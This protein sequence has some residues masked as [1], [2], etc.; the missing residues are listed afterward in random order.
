[1]PRRARPAGAGLLEWTIAFPVFLLLGLATLQVILIAFHGMYLDYSAREVARKVSVHGL[2]WSDQERFASEGLS[3][4]WPGQLVHPS[5]NYVK[6]RTL[7]MIAVNRLSPTDQGI[8]D[9]TDP[10]DGRFLPLSPGEGPIP[11][12]RSGL[13][14]LAEASTVVIELVS[15]YELSIPF[16]GRLL[17]ETIAWSRGCQSPLG[18]TEDC[19]FLTGKHPLHPG[20]TMLPITRQGR[21]LLQPAIQVAGG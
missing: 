4:M 19:L 17:S 21:A 6:A 16:A 1:M 2:D 15:R 14:P 13:Q 10:R 8:R 11:A 3:W 20:K 18:L 12:P 7:R 5:P 9:W